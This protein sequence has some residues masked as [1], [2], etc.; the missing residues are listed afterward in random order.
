[1]SSSK[2]PE[3]LPNRPLFANCEM[4]VGLCAGTVDVALQATLRLLELNFFLFLFCRRTGLNCC[5]L[6]LPNG[7]ILDCDS[8]IL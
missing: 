4:S 2:S 5:S 1:M 3:E 6:S 8:F 7:G